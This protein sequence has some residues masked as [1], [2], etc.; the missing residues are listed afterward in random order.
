[1]IQ[2][3][4]NK[5]TKLLLDAQKIVAKPN[6]TTEERAQ[7]HAMLADVDLIEQDIAI[8]DR[9]AKAEAESR[10]AGRPP[11][12]QPGEG[13]VNDETRSAEKRAFVDYLK[14][15]QIDRTSLREQRDLSTTNTGIIVAQDFLGQLLEAK[16]AWGAIAT[17]VGQKVTRNGEP[18]RVPGVDDTMNMS[19]II[20]ESTTNAPVVVSEV[21][22]N[23]AGLIN[24]V[25][26]MSTGEIRL[27]L[28]ELSDSYF[29]L[30]SWIRDAFGKRI[31]RGLAKLIVNGSADGNFASLLT[32]AQQTVT[33]P[34]GTSTTVTYNEFVAMYS[35]LDPAYVQDASWVFN[36]TVR[37]QILGLCD[38]LGRPLFVPSVNT[39]SLDRILGL[40]V[41]ISQ[42]HPNMGPSVA[43]AIQLSSLKDAYT[44][45]TAG[46]VSI[47]RL[48]ERY[49]DQGQVA[50]IGYHRNSGWAAPV[51]APTVNYVN[52]AS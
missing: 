48:N 46:E 22:P 39:D 44:L 5:R 35:K 9:A 43:G 50:F 16:K 47:L 33:A 25:S 29:D 20:G 51:G 36:N 40:P 42:F 49:A 31:A 27:S 30:E 15:G 3:L 52:S 4:R 28:A 11:R 12:S 37:G 13:A 32:S 45:R 10:A 34:T 1:M 23:F 24:N 18:I 21:D 19:T 14:T 26:F 41:V 6:V 2:E 7:A 8:H 17:A 38:S